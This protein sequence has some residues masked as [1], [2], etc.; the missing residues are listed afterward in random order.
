MNIQKKQ[1]GSGSQVSQV[2]NKPIPSANNGK[3]ADPMGNQVP[4]LPINNILAEKIANDNAN[5]TNKIK[6]FQE[7]LDKFIKEGLLA[8]SQEK[9]SQENI[10]QEKSSL[11]GTSW[12]EIITKI[13]ARK[14]KS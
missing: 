10:S 7:N 14:C 8:T 4:L 2:S 3:S 12:S 1:I 9:S 13:K 11:S 6:T 5:Y